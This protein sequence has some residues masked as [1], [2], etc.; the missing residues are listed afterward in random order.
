MTLL[1]E[2]CLQAETF[3]RL[4]APVSDSRALCFFSNKLS[5]QAEAVAAAGGRRD[6]EKQWLQTRGKA[7]CSW[8]LHLHGCDREAGMG[9][10]ECQQRRFARLTLTNLLLWAPLTCRDSFEVLCAS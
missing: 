3:S 9:G 10:K 2:H 1:N 6:L 5:A 4:L 8:R 7:C